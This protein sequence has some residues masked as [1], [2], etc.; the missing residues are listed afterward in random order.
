[1]VVGC[2]QHEQNLDSLTKY[3]LYKI[4]IILFKY[5]KE[6]Y[7]TKTSEDFQRISFK[8]VFLSII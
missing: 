8:K 2:D 5:A 1:M 3:R 7:K 6:S 4:T